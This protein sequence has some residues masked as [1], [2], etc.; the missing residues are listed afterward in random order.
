MIRWIAAMAMLAGTTGAMAQGGPPPLRIGVLAD[1][2]GTT[3]DLG[4]RGSVAAVQLAVEDNGGSV[5][6]RRIEV[7]SADTQNKP[8]VASNIARN[9]IDT[10]GVEAIADLPNTATALAVQNVAREKKKIT[11]ISASASVDLYGK[12]CSPTGFLWT[13]DTLVL[14]RGSAQAMYAAGATKWYF[15]TA[16]F[17]FAIQLETDTVAQIKALGGTMVGASR[18]PQGT[19]DFSAP[20]LQA[21]SSGANAVGLA[22]AGLDMVNAI[23]GANEFGLPRSGQKVA[24]MVLFEPDVRGAGLAATGGTYVTTAFYW[25]MNDETRAWSKRFFDR[26]QRM[27][28]MVQVA[29]Y[30]AA[31]HYLQAVAETGTD[32]TETVMAKMKATPVNDVFTKNGRIRPDGLHVH[33]MYLMQVKTPAE[34]K[35]SWDYYKVLSTVPAEEAFSPM[36]PGQCAFLAGK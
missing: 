6:G 29:M 26:T 20:L 16:D 35:L 32:K 33:D 18:V 5:L 12:Y 2:A 36:V 23:K 31:R 1:M 13:Y 14:A 11:L 15:V 17:S 9:W 10:E 34:S 28:T 7:L 22:L 8:D 21:Q 25:D 19:T 24:G 27:P 3:S 4:G 30:S